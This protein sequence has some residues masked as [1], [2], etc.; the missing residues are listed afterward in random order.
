MEQ[1]LF[2]PKKKSG[3][4]QGPGKEA[5]IRGDKAREGRARSFPVDSRRFF[6]LPG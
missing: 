3:K 1:P 6:S 2:Y 4:I 5:G